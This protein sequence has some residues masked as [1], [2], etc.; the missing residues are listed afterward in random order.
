MQR[1]RLRRSA[2]A[3]A[4]VALAATACGGDDTADPVE[5]TSETEM[6][7]ETEMETETDTEAAGTESET[8]TEAEPVDIAGRGD[9]TFTIGRVLPETG[10]LDYL[11]GP[12][13][14]GVSLAVSDINE[15]GGVLDQD[16]V[17][18]EKDSGTDPTVAVPNVN[19]ALAE[20]ADVIIGAAASGVSQQFLDTL[21][22]NT[23]YQCS[24]SATSPSF[25]EQENASH[26]FRTVPPDEAVAPVIAETIVGDGN[27]DN[28]VIVARSD[29]YGAALGGLIAEELT[30]L[31]ATV[32]GD[33]IT[34]TDEEQTFDTQA[35]QIVD[36]QPSAVVF[37]SFK[38]A[39]TLINRTLEL[40][41][42]DVTADTFYGADGIFSG[43]LPSLVDPGNANVIDGMKVIGA[44]GSDEFNSRLEEQGVNDFIYGGQAYDCTILMA[45]WAE[46]SGSDDTTT[47]DPQVLIDLTKE[48]T[49]CSTFADCKQIIADGGDVDYEGASGPITLEPA[50]NL[51]NPIVST[52][53][54]AQFQDGA[55]T[56]IDSQVVELN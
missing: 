17:L 56:S 34:Y 54:V 23:V 1:S 29:D 14:A 15:A 2:A 7:S 49:A 11:G 37:V 41:G 24:P 39:G 32:A 20:G 35:Q 31:G 48:G 30:N 19:S 27:G 45:L 13:I 42:G 16:V 43:Q 46:A 26:F 22:Q 51:G 44:S 5:T 38:E 50:T 36:A 6:G 40:G 8:E 3:V 21:N 53:S 25:N 10:F 52:Y 12:M 18:I 55:L 4:L 47:W 9:G 28:V 33:P